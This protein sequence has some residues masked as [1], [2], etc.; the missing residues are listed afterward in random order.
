MEK[1]QVFNPY[2]PS[3]EYV[4]DGEPHVFGSRIYVYGS[5][6]RFNGEKFCMNDYVCYS[7]DIHDLTNWRYEGVIYKKV[8]D[9]RNPDGK[10][11]MWA[12]D[13]TRGLDGRYYLY[14]CLDILPQI[15]VAVSDTPTGNYQFLGFVK[16]ADGT[17]LGE[18]KG[19]YIQFDPGIFID[20]D[21]EIYLYSGNAPMNRQRME[22]EKNGQP[23]NSQVMTLERD[24]VTLKTE[25]RTLIPTILNG[26]GTGFEKH[27]FF[28]ASSIRKINGIYYFIYSS[29]QSHELCYCTSDRPDRGYRYGGTIVSIGDIF[30]KGREKKDALNHLGNTH[31]GIEKIN[32]KWY[33]FYHRQ[34]NRTQYSRQACAEEIHFLPDGSIPQVE[35]T[36]SGL[37]GG[38][39]RGMGEYEAR[40]ACHLLGKKGVVFSCPEEMTEE[41]PYF[42]QDGEDREENPGQYI[43]N[44]QDGAIAGY[45][46][47]AF[48]NTKKITV[49][50]RLSSTMSSAEVANGYFLIS[51]ALRREY[52]G[53]IPVTLGR[54]TDEGDWRNFSASVSI[55]EGT[56]PLYLEYSGLGAVDL[57][58]FTLE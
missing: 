39:L 32:G 44:M 42:T 4:P 53:E 30:L 26:E 10:H 11:C 27:E 28:E 21:G 38:P 56:W 20:D 19:D 3:Y 15:G 48:R 24:M 58:S 54:N 25:P 2:L 43:A 31:G 22:R 7:A 18:G 45:K 35:I 1:R 34:T 47:F 23:K 52:V 55:P 50:V 8:Q 49:R 36:S 46:Y 13:V 37:N 12:P 6:D 40:I 29:V 51:L 33:V 17:L 16:H 14:Y 57:F 9:P 41:Y 5:H